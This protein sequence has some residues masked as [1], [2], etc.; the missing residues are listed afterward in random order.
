MPRRDGS[1][2]REPGGDFFDRLHPERTRS[3]LVR[4]LQRLGLDVILQPRSFS[5]AA[6]PALLSQAQPRAATASSINAVSAAFTA[7]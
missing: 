1:T 4:R 3:R 2:Y 7:S 5:D 6:A